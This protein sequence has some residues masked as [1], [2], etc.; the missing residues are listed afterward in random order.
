MPWLK[1]TEL[2]GIIEKSQTGLTI[3]VDQFD[4]G[5]LPSCSHLTVAEMDCLDFLRDEVKM[6][7]TLLFFKHIFESIV[8]HLKL[9]NN[10]DCGPR[11]FY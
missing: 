5:I 3:N 2:I 9:S 8:C 10:V 1:F 4:A 6:I 11:Y 7:L